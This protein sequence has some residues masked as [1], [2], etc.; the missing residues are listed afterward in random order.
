VIESCASDQIT[1]SLDLATDLSAKR[2]LADRQC[3][4]QQRS[5]TVWRGRLALAPPIRG[6]CVFQ[7]SCDG[8]LRKA[9]CEHRFGDARLLLGALFKVGFAAAAVVNLEC[10]GF[11]KASP[12][13]IVRQ[14]SFL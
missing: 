14:T 4:A 9:W 13:E 6:L 2:H 7:I 8:V 3:G 11:S 1:T 10:S 5:G 12:R